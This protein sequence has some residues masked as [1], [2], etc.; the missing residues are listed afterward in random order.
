M[1][2]LNPVIGYIRVS[3]SFVIY[4]YNIDYKESRILCGVM[5][6]GVRD[7]R[8][9]RKLHESDI[10]SGSKLYFKVYRSV[11]YIDEM[12]SIKAKPKLGYLLA[13]KIACCEYAV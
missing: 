5:K 13:E 4:V 3:D 6:D 7:R 10:Y 9:W 8:H 1:G 12:K 11:Y 2:T